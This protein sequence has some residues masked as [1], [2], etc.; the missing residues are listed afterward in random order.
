MIEIDTGG[1]GGTRQVNITHLAGSWSYFNNQIA[2][3]EN[4]ALWYY[5]DYKKKLKVNF[6]E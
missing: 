2:S 3:E 6:S 4:I 5:Y 1:T